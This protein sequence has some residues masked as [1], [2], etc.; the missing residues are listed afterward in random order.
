MKRTQP[1]LSRRTLIGRALALGLAPLAC[2]AER[3]WAQPRWAS[4]VATDAGTFE[5]VAADAHGVRVRLASDVRGHGLAVHE[6]APERVV[7]FG[8]RP[9]R[10]AIV[11]DLRRGAVVGRIE[12]P[13]ERHQS[14][15]GCFGLD[16][17]VLYVVEADNVSGHGFIAVLDA[18]TLQRKA[19][20]ATHG[21]GP[22]D[23]ALLP[24]GSA[25]VV[26]NGGL[27]TEPGGRD[28]INLDTMASSLVYLD[29]RTGALLETHTVAETKA[30]LRHL[31]VAED[32]T[33]AVAMQIQ[34]AA[35]DDADPRPLIGVRAPGEPLRA[36]EDGLDLS[37]AMEDYAGAIAIDSAT[38]VAAITSPR[39]NLIGFWK[40]DGGALV[41]VHAFD[42]VS[43]VAQSSDGE[44]FVFTGSNGQLRQVDTLALEELPGAR[45][46]FGDVRWDNHL[47]ALPS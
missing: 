6:V 29:P 4:A 37:T 18:E 10:I 32:G 16:G 25:I 30:S 20:F 1:Q 2:D 40:L 35:L 11:G 31:A 33:V 34:R 9:E 45:H 39:G 27:I 7:M 23:L 42:D 28:P 5:L 43:G 19:E 12:S 21:I 15:H 22:H 13:A 24:D 14:G 8:R 3:A 17:S 36:L 46:Q 47:I 44:R 38:R 41:G 26:A